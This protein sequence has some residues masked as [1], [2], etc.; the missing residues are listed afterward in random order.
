M[1]R[2][3]KGKVT[4]GRIRQG[5]LPSGN[6][7]D[8][9][10]SFK[11]GDKNLSDAGSVRGTVVE[12]ILPKGAS[13]EADISEAKRGH[14]RATGRDVRDFYDYAG[15]DEHVA[16]TSGYWLVFKEIGPL[17]FEV[18]VGAGAA[19]FPGPSKPASTSETE[20]RTRRL[21]SVLARP[22]QAAF[23]RRVAE[24]DGWICAVSGCVEPRAL[25]A[26]HLHSVADGGNDDAANGMMLRADIHRLFDADLLTIDAATGEVAL[27]PDV[28]DVDYGALAGVIVSTG[29]DLSHL[30]ARYK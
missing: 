27:S 6:I 16:E 20:K 7:L 29:A 19:G 21:A 10:P 18:A 25:E 22:E 11:Y 23:R 12:I 13:I 14:F 17:R 8:L 9:V 2:F 4:D 24:R 1:T 26:A 30:E 3:F 28:E 5:Q 15:F